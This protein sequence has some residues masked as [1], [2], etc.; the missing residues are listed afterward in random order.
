M[1]GANLKI[2]LKERS[3]EMERSDDWYAYLHVEQMGL[4]LQKTGRKDSC[5]SAFKK[6]TNRNTPDKQTEQT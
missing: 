3:E 2:V 4:K 1:S 6:R 5:Q